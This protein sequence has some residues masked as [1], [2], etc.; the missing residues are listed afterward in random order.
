MFT[1]FD[2]VRIGQVMTNLISNSINNTPPGGKIDVELLKKNGYAFIN[3][4]DNGIGITKEEME[5]LF[6]KF[7]KIE[8]YG[9]DLDV[10]TEGTGLGLYISKEIIQLHDGEIIAASE[11]RNKGSIFTIKLP[12]VHQ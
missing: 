6:Q 10:Y 8:R 4:K 7:G 2:S 11:G 12:I 3:V 1:N 5:R 9:K